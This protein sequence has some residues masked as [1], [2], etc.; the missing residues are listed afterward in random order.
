M[1]IDAIESFSVT[2]I[3]A[4]EVQFSLPCLLSLTSPSF[5]HHL[6]LMFR[7]TACASSRVERFLDGAEMRWASSDAET[8]SQNGCLDPFLSQRLQSPHFD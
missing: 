1:R 7:D 4:G 3:A 2:D 6:Y 8:E 5:T